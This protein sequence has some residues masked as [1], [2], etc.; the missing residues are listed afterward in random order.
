MRGNTL[1]FAAFLFTLGWTACN[2]TQQ[3]SAY[4]TGDGQ[5][6]DII[7]N[8]EVDNAFTQSP[9][10]KEWDQNSD[11]QVD[12]DE[13]YQGHVKVMDKDQNS[14]ISNEEWDQAKSSYFAGYDNQPENMEDW[15]ADGDGDLTTEEVVTALED[16]NYYK[17][18]DNNSDGKIVEEEFAKNVF[19]TWDTDDNGLVQSEEYGEFHERQKQ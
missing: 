14:S 12:E 2:D 19:Q 1:F 3:G 18:W 11:Q 8:S 5:Q 7:D 9:Y 13:F 16:T 15:D 4:D 10:F 17:N 6:N